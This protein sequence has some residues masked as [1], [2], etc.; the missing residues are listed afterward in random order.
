MVTHK[1]VSLRLSSKAH[2]VMKKRA[3]CSLLPAFCCLLSAVC[4][5]LFAVCFLLSAVCCLLSAACCLLSA[6]CCLLSAL[7]YLLSAICYLLSAICYLLSA[8][9]YLLSAIYYLS[10]ICTV[11]SPCRSVIG[12]WVGF[13]RIG[14]DSILFPDEILNR[15]PGHKTRCFVQEGPD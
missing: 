13:V 14:T 5:F 15:F 12:Y 6:V 9:C 4:C 7:C 1:A 10:A 11:N 2:G 3:I 8:I